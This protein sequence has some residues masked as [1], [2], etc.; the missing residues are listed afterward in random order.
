M[1]G[2]VV[3]DAPPALRWIPLPARARR[4]LG[5]LIEK[6]KTTPDVYPLTLNALTTGCN[7]KSNRDPLM[8]LEPDDVE[9]CLEELRA[10]GAVVE[11]AGSGR[12][13]KY[14]HL[15]YDWLGVDK[16]ELAVVGEL[17]LRGAQ[18]VG[19]LR[20]RAARMEPI[21]GLN[22]LRPIVQSLI[23]KRLVLELTPEGRGQ[24]VSHNLYPPDELE[25]IELRMA[26][27]DESTATS[28][29]HP[30]SPNRPNAPTSPATP[31]ATAVGARLDTSRQTEPATGRDSRVD[32]ELQWLRGEIELLRKDLT[33][34][35]QDIHDLW[36]S[37]Q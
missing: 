7:Q 1:S 19:E 20:G 31:P 24:M 36:K 21:A 17:L 34:L 25:R 30:P 37:L 32:A 35:Q 2:E 12:V 8:E 13:S 10:L 15:L 3:S 9:E 22:E 27:R 29:S 4:V 28:S 18:T 6:A 14:R 33:R 16:V 11:V 23:R 5:V 26:A